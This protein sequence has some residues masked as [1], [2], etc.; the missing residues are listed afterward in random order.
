MLFYR[1]YGGSS[2][3]AFE[4]CGEAV[5]ECELIAWCLL[6]ARDWD[7]SVRCVL[8][9]AVQERSLWCALEVAVRI[10][11]PWWRGYV[12]DAICNWSL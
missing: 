1:L 12:V 7:L 6:V 2:G 11:S 4:E 3:E 5:A 10:V 8:R 9:V